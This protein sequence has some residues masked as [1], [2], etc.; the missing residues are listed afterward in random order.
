MVLF[1]I[2]AT[3]ASFAYTTWDDRTNHLDPFDYTFTGAAYG[4]GR[5][6]L[7]GYNVS[8]IYQI[9]PNGR[10]DWTTQQ[11]PDSLVF[12]NDVAFGAGLF[13]VVGPAGSI[14]T[15]PTGLTN[16]WTT[17]AAGMSR[18]IRFVRYLNGMF[19][20]GTDRYNDPGGNTALS[21][22]EIL[23]SVTGDVWVS[24]KYPANSATLADTAYTITGIA[25]KPGA[26]GPGTGTWVL[27]ANVTNTCLSADESFN[28]LTRAAVLA[29]GGDQRIAYGNGSFV[30]TSATGGV[31]K[32]WYSAT[33]T[34]G[35]T[36]AALPNGMSV[37]D[38][39]GVFH[40]GNRFVAVGGTIAGSSPPIP[41]V[42]HSTDGVTWTQ[43]ATVPSTNGSLQFVLRADGLWLAGGS[44]KTRFTSGT[45]SASLAEI[46]VESPVDTPLIDGE[47][48]LDFGSA[49]VGQSTSL[50]IRVR[51]TGPDPLTGISATI[52]GTHAGDFSKTSVPASIAGGTFADFSVTFSPQADGVRTAALQINSN[53]DDEKTFD[54]ALTATGLVA[55]SAPAV[56][57]LAATA[58]TDVGASLQGKVNAK[59]SLSNIWFDYGTTTNLGTTAAGTPSTLSGSTE[60]TVSATLAGLASHT[61]YYYR[62]RADNAVGNANGATGSFTTANS[63]PVAVA[64]AYEIT[65]SATLEL[66]LLGNDVSSDGDLLSLVSNTALSPSSA[67]KLTKNGNKM[68]FAAAATFSGTATF[69]YV[70]KDMVGSPSNAATVTLTAGTCILDPTALTVPAAAASYGVGVT[71][72]ATWSVSESLSWITITPSSGT[73]N[74]NLAVAL[75]PNS[76]KNARSGNVAIGGKVLTI[77]QNGVQRPTLA[78]PD[79]VPSGIVGSP[80]QLLVPA[81]NF[82]MALTAAN[83]PPGLTISASGLIGGTPTKGGSYA[84]TVKASNA[85]G[86]AE[87]SP[88]FNIAIA[89]LPDGIVGPFHGLV[90]SHS[91]IN[92]KLGSRFELTTTSTGACSGKLITGASTLPFGGK[93]I[94]DVAQPNQAG[95]Q[96]TIPRKGTSSLILT[97]LLDHASRIFN[98]KL[99]NSPA[100]TPVTAWTHDWNS[101]NRRATPYAGLYTFSLTPNHADPAL[102][103]GIG[104]GSFKMASDSTGLVS[105][106]GKLPDGSKFTSGTFI[107]HAGQVLL[108]Q[109]LYSGRG[110]FAGALT[111]DPAAAAP[112]SKL[113]HLITPLWVKGAPPSNSTD[114]LYKSG[115]EPLQLIVFGGLLPPLAPGA[116]IMD[117][118]ASANNATVSFEDG[119]LPSPADISFQIKNPS[120]TART[121]SVVIAANSSLTMPAFNVATGAFGGIWTVPGATKALNR[122]APYEGLFVMTPYGLRGLGFFLLPE[123]TAATSPKR[124]GSVLL[125]PAQ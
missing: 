84:V 26:G 27:G 52:T 90:E 93:L 74:G 106:A 59:G 5:F 121:N 18:N 114:T 38:M 17:R 35:W 20:A 120:A 13:V 9:S 107:G 94:T 33:G 23:T 98:G 69:T 25:F 86:A 60:T 1:S 89:A 31:G 53:D 29:V 122:K 16:S 7:L 62:V 113:L 44:F 32:I 97:G 64:D 118:P 28:T 112:N 65:P 42:L 21:Y 116:L 10:T 4:A 102:P 3:A 96:L 92:G 77:V 57:T 24:H 125:Q 88:A 54:I 40:D 15:S 117:L 109:S 91:A 124:S 80:Y 58:V 22:T 115:F 103:Q 100:E 55:P 43:A 11:L 14:F 45:S 41:A 101:T 79:P 119:G 37:P 66:N 81:A 123:T 85:A 67:G 95:L 50:S 56:T 87:V 36:Q 111:I 82:P 104:F 34:G 110:S 46:E 12:P 73:G 51:N 105:I 76:S 83:L 30:I 72:T 6:L 49:N 47:S 39:T 70:I 71:T 99:S 108:Y 78:K 8:S 2:L 75:Q 19:V 68:T 63:V 48:T 61:R